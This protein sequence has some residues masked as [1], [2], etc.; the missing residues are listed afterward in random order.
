M[1]KLA[2][3]VTCKMGL[4]SAECRTHPIT[5]FALSEMELYIEIARQAS[6]YFGDNKKVKTYM[7]W[8]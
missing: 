1:R 6:W 8:G 3:D 2:F 5:A 7:H 4:L